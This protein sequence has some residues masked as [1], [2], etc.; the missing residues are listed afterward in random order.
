MEDLLLKDSALE[1][2]TMLRIN[3]Q[4]EILKLCDA[5]REILNEIEFRSFWKDINEVL[6]S[7]I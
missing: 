5:K 4:K 3:K 1:K 7:S 6:Q 2:P